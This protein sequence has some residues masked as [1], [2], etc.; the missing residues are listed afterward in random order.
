MPATHGGQERTPEAQQRSLRGRR[1]RA[2]RLAGVHQ[3]RPA[4]QALVGQDATAEV[5][6]RGR[7][8]RVQA[9]GVSG[10]P[11]GVADVGQGWSQRGCA[12]GLAQLVQ[13]GAGGDEAGHAGQVDEAE[14]AGNL[15]MGENKDRELKF[16]FYV[17][18]SR[19]R[20]TQRELKPERP[21][22]TTWNSWQVKAYSRCS[23]LEQHEE[24]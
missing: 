1:R 24:E 13:H 8:F 18:L 14:H 9:G 21:G 12:P 5:L 16:D 15:R 19:C 4:A 22:A 17:I 6:G 2:T 10:E 23:L 20:E 7:G 3:V 11:V